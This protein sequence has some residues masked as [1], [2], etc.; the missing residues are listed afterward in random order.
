MGIKVTKEGGF[1]VGLGPIGTALVAMAPAYPVAR[2]AL[3]Q[4]M[5]EQI[6][7]EIAPLTS[8][9]EVTINQNARTLQKTIV[10][11]EFKRDN[12]TPKPM[13]WTVYDAED[14]SNAREDLAAALKASSH[15]N[16]LLMGMWCG[17]TLGTSA[18][19]AGLAAVPI[20]QAVNWAGNAL[21]GAVV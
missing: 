13:C 21:Y 10:A 19:V 6:R 17:I 15:R 9:F 16:D 3:G 5:K 8:A 2:A 1:M 4:E 7:Q 12:C 11:L 14:L 18:G 20:A